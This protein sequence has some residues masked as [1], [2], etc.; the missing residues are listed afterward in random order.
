MY[1]RKPLPYADQI[2]H[3]KRYLRRLRTELRHRYDEFFEATKGRREC[4]LE[5]QLRSRV[6]DATR[7]IVALAEACLQELR[8]QEALFY[9]PFKPGDLVVA[10]YR[11]QDVT[12]SLGMYLIIDVCPDK[13]SAFHYEALELTKSGAIHK[14]RTRRWL[15]PR[16]C[17]TL[18]TSD[19]SVPEETEQEATYYRECAKTS[20][21]RAF[22][23]G[24]LSM[25]EAVEGYLG[26][27][28]FRRTDRMSL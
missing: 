22:E 1:P 2:D 6:L 3:M 13:R 24:D 10:D 23:K 21:I 19:V 4:A 18:R 11:D 20:R 12:R 14:R 27:K 7:D 9:S 25:F 17:L 8:R 28:R 5:V 16:E 15:Y 26:G